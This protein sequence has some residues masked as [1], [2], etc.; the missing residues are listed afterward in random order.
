MEINTAEGMAQAVAWQTAHC[1][2][3]KEGGTWAVPRSGTVIIISHKNKQATFYGLLPEPDIGRVF[4]AMGWVVVG[5]LN[6][7]T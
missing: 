5:G 1:A 4:E 2:L 6:G 3:I 7:T